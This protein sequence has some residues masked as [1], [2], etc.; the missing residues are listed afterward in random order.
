MY[1]GIYIAASGAVLKEA[2]LSVTA[3]NLANASTAGY[4]K[5]RIS[6]N[7]Y[8]LEGVEEGADTERAMV[9]QGGVLTDFSAGEFIRTGNPLDM[10]LEG[11]G[12]FALEGGRFT[13]RGDFRLDDEGYLVN[14]EGLKV[15]GE[16]ESPLLIPPGTVDVGP[17]GEITVD[18][19][20]VGRL[21]IVD[22]PRPYALV[23]VGDAAYRATGEAVAVESSARV[24]QG[25]I[26]GSN[27][28]VIKEM[29]GMIRTSR[30]FETYQKI[31]RAFDD[32]AAKALNE[33]GRL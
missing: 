16:D 5:E 32:A 29:V 3:R 4:K 28:S 25:V 2:E 8:L 19:T 17:W 30:E 14:T 31:I 1:K 12:F 20:V 33:I 10:A 9:E 11:D 23:R 13:R 27:V 6:F 18:G 7:S 24:S 22:F 21:R 26:E 15:L